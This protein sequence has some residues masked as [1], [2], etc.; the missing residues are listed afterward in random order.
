MLGLGTPTLSGGGLSSSRGLRGGGLG[1]GLSGLGLLSL[2]LFSLGFL[3]LLFF[4]LLLLLFLLLLSLLLLAKERS[5]KGGALAR[6]RAA[7]GVL[8][9]VLFSR[10]RSSSSSSSSRGLFLL[11]GLLVIFLLSLTLLSLLLGFLLVLGG[12]SS[13]SSNNRLGQLLK[14][15]LVAL[16]RGDGLLLSLGLGGLGLQGGDPAVA[17]S[18][19]GGLEGVLVAVQL[20]EELIG[21]LL[22][23]IGNIGLFHVSPVPFGAIIHPCGTYQADDASGSSLVL[24]TLGEEEQTLAGL[25]GPGDDRVGDSGLLVATEDGQLLGLDSI[26]AEVEEALGEAEAPVWRP[27]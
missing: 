9:L 7:L 5:E 17:L 18:S 19:V 16:T 21:A 15:S 10:G 4:L 11:L 14:L 12:L 24:S 3:L 26:V 1:G 8:L 6:A 25:A 27:Y 13:G 23:N 2:G 20:E 22:G